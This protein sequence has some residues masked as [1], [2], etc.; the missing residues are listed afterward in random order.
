MAEKFFF[1]PIIHSFHESR[2][3]VIFERTASLLLF[4]MKLG[5]DDFT[6]LVRAFSYLSDAFS[7]LVRAFFGL[8][9]AFSGPV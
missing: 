5:G 6:Q 4:M 9:G 2:T 1:L 7:P 3:G 8:I